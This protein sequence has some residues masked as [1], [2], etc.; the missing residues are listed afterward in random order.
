MG[1]GALPAAGGGS[2]LQPNACLSVPFF[3][4][5]ANVP[6]RLQV[7]NITAFEVCNV[8]SQLLNAPWQQ[9]KRKPK[10]RLKQVDKRGEKD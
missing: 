3:H 2:R 1:K 4:Y 9:P 7:T 5:Q 8:G 6:L 10:R